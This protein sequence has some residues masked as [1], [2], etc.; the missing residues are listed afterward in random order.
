MSDMSAQANAPEILQPDDAV[1]ASLMSMGF[2]ENGSKRAA[3]ATSNA[4]SE[5]AMEWV[6]A[7]MEDSDF[8][9]PLPSLEEQKSQGAGGCG[10]FQPNEEVSSNQWWCVC[11][12]ILLVRLTTY[13]LLFYI[14]IY[15]YI[16][17]YIYVCIHNIHTYI[18][19]NVIMFECE[20]VGVGCQYYIRYYSM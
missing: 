12:V 15:I 17:V 11:V 2:S 9:D 18:Y 6:F 13:V 8:N 16:Y 1:V 5:V 19:T 7:H 4:S 14:Y 3:V 20:S 10:G